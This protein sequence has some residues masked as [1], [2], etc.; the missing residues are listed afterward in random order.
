[1]DVITSIRRFYSNSITDAEKQDAINLFLGNYVPSTPGQPELWELENDVYLHAT[2]PSTGRRK[3]DSLL[4]GS[5]PSGPPHS[6][7]DRPSLASLASLSSGDEA[8]PPTTSGGAP[9]DSLD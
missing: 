6:L 9:L 8:D 5:W 7:S 3:R 1:M 4:A 2:D